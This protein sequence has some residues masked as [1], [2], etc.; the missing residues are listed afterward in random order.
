[1]IAFTPSLGR[2]RKESH[3]SGC[4]DATALRRRGCSSASILEANFRWLHTS[5]ASVSSNSRYSSAGRTLPWRSDSD[6]GEKTI[7]GR[8]ARK[9]HR[10]EA[11]FARAF[12][13][14]VRW[15]D[16]YPRV[17]VEHGAGAVAGMH[18]REYVLDHLVVGI[19]ALARGRIQELQRLGGRI[20]LEDHVLGNRIPDHI[21]HFVCVPPA[22]LLD[23]N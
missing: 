21:K 4:A 15:I 9:H 10:R 11:L 12:D 3:A 14:F 17:A 22:R 6:V 23:L 5:P 13:G 7:F 8:Y 1:M 19:D 18:A 20:E 2:A 16:E